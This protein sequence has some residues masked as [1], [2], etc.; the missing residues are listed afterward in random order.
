MPCLLEGDSTQDAN[1]VINLDPHL[2]RQ[3][4]DEA[5]RFCLMDCSSG[6]VPLQFLTTLGSLLGAMTPE[7]EP[8]QGNR[9]EYKQLLAIASG[10][11]DNG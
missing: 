3:R 7:R 8:A 5:K 10:D 4:I 11:A 2:G 9:H 6:I 1:P